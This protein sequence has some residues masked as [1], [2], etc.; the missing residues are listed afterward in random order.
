M[1]VRF[2][3]TPDELSAVRREAERRKVTVSQ[4]AGQIVM[5]AVLKDGGER[6]VAN[7]MVF[8]EVRRFRKMYCSV[9]FK[10]LSGTLT[11]QDIERMEKE[12]AE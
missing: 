5:H 7:Q 4:L 6:D 10:S 12:S 1:F 11:K 8:E 3:L 2:R 9:M